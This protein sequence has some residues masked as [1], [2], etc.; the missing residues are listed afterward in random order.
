[1]ANFGPGGRRSF[2][3]NGKLWT[4]RGH[5]YIRLNL[6]CP[7]HSTF[8]VGQ[9]NAAEADAALTKMGAGQFGYNWV[10]VFIDEGTPSRATGINGNGQTPLNAAYIANIVD[11]LQRAQY[12][13]IFVQIQ[14]NTNFPQS[15]YWINMA[16]NAP[17]W[18]GGANTL[19]LAPAYVSTFATYVGL[20]AQTLSDAM[21]GDTS[22]ILSISVMN[23]AAFDTSSLPFASNTL[24]I[25]T[26]DGQTYDMGNAAS[27]QQCVDANFVHFSGAAASSIRAAVP[28]LLVTMGMFTFAAVGK[29]GGPNGVA[30]GG[31]TRYP[32]NPPS[33]ALYSSLDYLDLHVYP[34]GS[35]NAP[36]A[37]SLYRDLDSS[38]VAACDFTRMCILVGE[39]GSFKDW[40]ASAD[41]A[42]FLMASI[43]QQS[44]T[45][46]KY[47]FVGGFGL[48]TWD[49]YEQP[50]I[51]N[52]LDDN[53]AIAYYLSPLRQP[54]IC[55]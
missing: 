6:T 42:A 5:N 46:N 38:S 24:Q 23:E 15:A 12:H 41:D 45:S 11:F 53:G 49:T 8:T 40:V 30:P 52:A 14:V 28:S 54:V 39:F 16:G 22:P 44:C 27:R 17:A 31:D 47:F 9:Y 29:S 37:G 2:S 51:W 32:P 1:M 21:K 4:A 3:L 20:L 7:C 36:N 10:R 43:Q 26:A 50:N 35:W 18:S 55:P 25:T 33:L 34:T 48:W 13:G 19:Y